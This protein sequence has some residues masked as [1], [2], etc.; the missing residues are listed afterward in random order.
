MYAIINVQTQTVLEFPVTNIRKKFPNMS[1]PRNPTNANLPPHVRL[2]N[3]PVEPAANLTMVNELSPPAYSQA[4]KTWSCIWT[5]RPKTASEI[6]TTT[7]E[8]LERVTAEASQMLNEFAIAKGYD[9]IASLCNYSTSTDATFKTEADRGILIRDQTW[10]AL[11]E[12]GA[13]VKAGT[14]S[15]PTT[16]AQVLAVIPPMTW[17]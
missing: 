11:R 9:D 8:V 4:T 17:Y 15:L 14:Q 13:A 10:I 5:D 7:E 16:I 2:V 6:T 1:F 3:V 12:Y